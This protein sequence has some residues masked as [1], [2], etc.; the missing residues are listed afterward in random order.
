M[1]SERRSKTVALSAGDDLFPGFPEF[2]E[3]TQS[4][5]CEARERP[6]PSRAICH[7]S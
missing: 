7:R 1:G 2:S 6:G 3:L 4:W 5:R